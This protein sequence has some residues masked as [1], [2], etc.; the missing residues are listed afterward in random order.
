MGLVYFVQAGDDGPIK[1]GTV[2][3]DINGRIASLQT[4]SSER[5]HLRRA[6]LGDVYEEKRL[7]ERFAASRLHGEWFMLSDE[8]SEFIDSL[9]EGIPDLPD[10]PGIRPEIHARRAYVEDPSSNEALYDRSRDLQY[11]L[12]K[13]IEGFVDV[14]LMLRKA[15]SE[16]R[17]DFDG[18]ALEFVR[19]VEAGR[20]FRYEPPS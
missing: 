13:G 19:Q 14:M 11:S 12:L 17:I 9:P 16:G 3:R 5:L 20:T 1:I 4:G 6:V 7:H 2:K 10:Q 15:Q 8:L 18:T